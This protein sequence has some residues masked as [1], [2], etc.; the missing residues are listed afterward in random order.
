MKNKNKNK[1]KNKK[2]LRGISAALG[3]W[4]HKL[5]KAKKFELS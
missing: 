2:F 4:P 1:N 5:I 3:R